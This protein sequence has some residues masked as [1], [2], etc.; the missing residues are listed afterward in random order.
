MNVFIT[1][2]VLSLHSE[3]TKPIKVWV[4]T[5]NKAKAEMELGI[6]SA[7]STVSFLQFRCL[8]PRH[9]MFPADIPLRTATSRI[10][11]PEDRARN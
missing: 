10:F 7:I 9:K 11:R 4:L 6:G 8:F 2:N 3:S 1:A 5:K